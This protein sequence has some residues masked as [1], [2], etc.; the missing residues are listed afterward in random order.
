[1]RRAR[2]KVR[3]LKRY[4]G[5]SAGPATFPN[6]SEGHNIVKGSKVKLD[7]SEQEN[8]WIWVFQ[9]CAGSE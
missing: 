9:R 6:S 5:A 1:M 7:V 4:Q 8:E 3:K 2:I